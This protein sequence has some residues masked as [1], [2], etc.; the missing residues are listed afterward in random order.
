MIRRHYHCKY[1]DYKR[2]DV[3]RQLI[4][5]HEETC[6]YNPDKRYCYSCKHHSVSY[7]SG[8]L[9]TLDNN[10]VEAYK[11][12]CKD[13]EFYKWEIKSLGYTTF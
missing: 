7:L 13:Y 11:G 1:C 2:N 6:G 4:K 9:C 3:N 5:K 12:T 8:E 10:K